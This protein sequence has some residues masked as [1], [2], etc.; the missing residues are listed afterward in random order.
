MDISK[1]YPP[2]E[3]PVSRGT[4]MIAPLIKWNHDEDWHIPFQNLD[5]HMNATSNGKLHS[6]SYDNDEFLYLRGHVIDGANV[7]PLS[8]YLVQ[9]FNTY[10]EQ[11]IFI[12]F[13]SI[14]LH[15]SVA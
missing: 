7:V 2:I 12:H 15:L 14:S 9:M 11:F 3:Y 6:I 8:L 4:P 5:L 1:L 13:N 10:I